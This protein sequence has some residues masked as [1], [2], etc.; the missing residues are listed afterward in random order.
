MPNHFD[1]KLIREYDALMN[2]WPHADRFR[3]DGAS[4][5]RNYVQNKSGKSEIIVYE[6]GCGKGELTKKLLDIDP[7]VRVIAAELSP[8]MAD[9]AQEQLKPYRDRC[10]IVQT[11][12]VSF[13][14]YL[15]NID[16]AISCWTLHNLRGQKNF[17]ILGKIHSALVNNGLFVNLDKYVPGSDPDVLQSSDVTTRL[18]IKQHFANLAVLDPFLRKTAEQHEYEDLLPENVQTEEHLKLMERVFGFEKV[19]V[20]ERY[21]LDA[22]VRAYK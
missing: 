19:L 22:I 12:A 17:A 1:E 9:F 3:S 20:L 8:V 14:D 2:A 7:R 16:V 5:V 13:T 11:D 10:T 18:A 4:L 21:G 15:R 6:I